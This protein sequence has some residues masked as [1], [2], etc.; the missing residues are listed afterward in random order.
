MKPRQTSNPKATVQ[1]R[2]GKKVLM[3]DR[4]SHALE[5]SR[6]NKSGWRS[7]LPAINPKLAIGICA[8]ILLIG[9]LGFNGIKFFSNQQAMAEKTAATAKQERLAEQSR[10]AS[11]CRQKK[12]A[13]KSDQIGKVTYDQLYDGDSCD[14]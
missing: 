3:A 7:I 5:L 6:N 11:E 10:A 12:A 8:G 2:I 1:R 13:A 14:R 9:A 4:L